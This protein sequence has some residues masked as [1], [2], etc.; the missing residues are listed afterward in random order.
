MKGRTVASVK[1]ELETSAVD[2][3]RM[4]FLEYEVSPELQNLSVESVADT[5]RFSDMGES[6]VQPVETGAPVV[7]GGRFSD[8]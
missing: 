7:D 2:S 4:A 6:L 3:A 5:N 1:E 8:L